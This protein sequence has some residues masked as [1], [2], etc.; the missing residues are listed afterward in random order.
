LT[1]RRFNRKQES[2]ADIFALEIIEKEYGTVVGSLDF[3]GR[4]G[5]GETAERV[6]NFAGTH[7]SSQKRIDEM[8]DYVASHGWTWEGGLRPPLTAVSGGDG[9]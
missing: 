1:S 6:A 5:V 4:V 7:P 3:F 8:R 9:R 2:A